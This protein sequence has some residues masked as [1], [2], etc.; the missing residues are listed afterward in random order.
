MCT[1]EEAHLPEHGEVLR[2]TV[3]SRTVSAHTTT[4]TDE[5]SWLDICP[6]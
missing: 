6:P 1:H 2:T 4:G 3:G 5:S